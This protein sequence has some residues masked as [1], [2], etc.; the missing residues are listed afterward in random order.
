MTSCLTPR[1]AAGAFALAALMSAP[2]SAQA[3][4][5]TINPVVTGPLA[6]TVNCTDFPVPGPEQLCTITPAP[7]AAYNFTMAGNCGSRVRLPDDPLQ[8]NTWLYQVGPRPSNPPN[9]TCNLTIVTALA[10]STGAAAIPTLSE[11]GLILMSMAAAGLG[12]AAL[13]RRN[14]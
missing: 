8:P 6:L 4:Y 9:A 3:Q 7:S 14:F 13:R 12:L 1:G 5:A 11:W 2:L 10:A